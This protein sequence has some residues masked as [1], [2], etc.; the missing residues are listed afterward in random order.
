M[1]LLLFLALAAFIALGAWQVRRMHWKHD[2]IARV[3]A[4]VHAAPVTLPPDAHL[5]AAVPG[6]FDYLRVRLSGVYRPSQTA[7]ARASTDLGTGYWTMTPL[8]MGDGRTIWVNRGFVAAGTTRD[9][10][11]ASVPQ[12]KAEVVGLLRSAEPGG[13]LLQSNRPREDRWYSRDLAALSKAKGTGRTAPVFVDAQRE[14]AA[15]PAP[16]ASPVP[17]L[18]VVHFPDNHLQYALTWFALS[19]LTAFGI[20]LVWRRGRTTMP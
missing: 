14:S 5:T 2:L 15:R 12:G 1:T 18:T 17:G 11:S 20:G 19:G 9:A 4:R 3:N 7:L 8:L 6:A 10:A 13:S 16:G